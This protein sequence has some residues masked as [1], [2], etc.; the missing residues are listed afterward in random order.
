MRSERASQKSQC[1]A[2]TVRHYTRLGLINAEA[3]SE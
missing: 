2:E 1:N 3:R